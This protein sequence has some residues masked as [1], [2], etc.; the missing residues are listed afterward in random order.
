[1]RKEADFR[2]TDKIVVYVANNE[3]IADIITGNADSIKADTLAEAIELGSM[4]GFTK[5]WNLNGEKVTMGVAQV[6]AL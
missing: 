1:M 4:S 5:E 3:K 2:V 6:S